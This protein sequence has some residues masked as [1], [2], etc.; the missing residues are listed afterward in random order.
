[1]PQS[2]GPFDFGLDWSDKIKGGLLHA[3]MIFAREKKG[4]NLLTQQYDLKN[5]KMS[6][7]LV[8]QNKGLII[9]N[10]YSKDINLGDYKLETNSNIAIIPNI[11]NYEFCDKDKLL[12]IYKRIIVKLLEKDKNIYI[13]SHSDDEEACNDIYKLCADN[14]RIF[15]YKNKLDCLEYSILVKQFQYIIA[16]RYHAIVHAYKEEVPCIAIGWAEKYE[17]LLNMFDQEKY[18]FDVR[19]KIDKG[20]ILGAIENMDKTW[21]QEK[22]KLRKILPRLQ[23]ENCFDIIE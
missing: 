12:Y 20:E 2:F 21:I 4:Y 13:L 14:K 15:M 3:S 18:V 19:E 10:I 6:K 16:S 11:R 5:V 9:E 8:L 7:D 1:M 23:M 17:E 22:E